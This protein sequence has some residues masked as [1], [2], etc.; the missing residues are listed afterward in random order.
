[1][2][3][4][5]GC[6]ERGFSLVEML[7]VVAIIGILANIAYPV[8]AGQIRKA[9]AT[10][11]VEDFLNVQ[12]AASTAST[13]WPREARARAR[14]PAPQPSSRTREGRGSTVRTVASTR[15]GGSSKY[16]GSPSTPRSR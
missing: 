16:Q 14:T 11:I 5:A 13:P 7:V 9:R 8:F 4:A 6:K 1:M 3:E 10:A 12:R 2:S 15:G